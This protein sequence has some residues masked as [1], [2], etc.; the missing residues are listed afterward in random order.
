MNDLGSAEAPRSSTK[1]VSGA[2]QGSTGTDPSYW[3]WEEDL[4][5]PRE[6]RA[7]RGSPEVK[8]EAEQDSINADPSCSRQG[9]KDQ[10]LV[11]VG[12]GFEPT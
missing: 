3:W 9:E 4:N 5:L 10:I 6:R 1:V 7:K 12:G 8:I 11:V 2:E